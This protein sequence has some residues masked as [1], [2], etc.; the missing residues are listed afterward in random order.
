M[1]RR[2]EPHSLLNA[3]ADST[4]TLW[5]LD[6]G[7]QSRPIISIMGNQLCTCSLTVGAEFDQYIICPRTAHITVNPVYLSHLPLVQYLPIYL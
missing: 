5:L 4:S 2:F 1:F 3:L 7:F 6:C